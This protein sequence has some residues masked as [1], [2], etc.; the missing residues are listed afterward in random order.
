MDLSDRQAKFF[1]HRVLGRTPVVSRRPAR[2]AARLLLR[3]GVLVYASLLLAGCATTLPKHYEVTPS[4]AYANPQV[5]ELGRILQPDLE[6]HPGQSGVKLL[7]GGKESF[8]ARLDLA[9][10]ADKTLDLQYYRWAADN[11]G[12]ILAARVLRAAD[13]GVRVRILIDD[14]NTADSDFRFARMDQHPN[15]EIRLFNPFRRR[16]FRLLDLVADL[17]RLNHRMHNKAFIA[18][19]TIAV[20]GGRNIGDEYF[21]DSPES[22]FRDLDVALAGP[23]VREIS[24]SFDEFWNSEWAVPIDAVVQEEMS[25]E[26]LEA[27]KNKLYL[28]VQEQLESPYRTARHPDTVREDFTDFKNDLT[29]VPA[30]IL[31]DAPHKLHSKIDEVAA[32]LREIDYDQELLMEAAYLIAGESGLERARYN[33]A[34]GIR[35]RILTNSLATN[36]VAAAHAG[37]AKYRKDLI[38]SGVELYEL[39]PDSHRKK[40]WKLLSTKSRASLH[41]KVFV[42]DRQTVAIGSFNA[43]P[44]SRHLNTEILILIESD[45]LAAEVMDYM[46]TGITPEASYRLTLEKSDKG[47]ERLV[48][49]TREDGRMVRYTSDPEVGFWRRFNAWFIS[50]FPIEKHL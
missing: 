49:T 43:D 21:D 36:D 32:G 25:P 16:A 28:W 48:W 12:Q 26:A 27:A 41:T 5:T 30:R 45:E 7:S 3:L 37:Y 20:M 35:T 29:W 23:V 15:I 13:R 24:T 40:K 1:S 44:R 11:S 18:D 39:R 38:R 42:A 33:Q 17:D 6:R 4:V 46:D 34:H 47:F 14:I 8:Q 2:P 22:N 19:N 10:L 9:T 31:Y 50:L